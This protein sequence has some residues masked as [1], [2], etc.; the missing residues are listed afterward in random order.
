LQVDVPDLL[1]DYHFFGRLW[2]LFFGSLGR[3]AFETLSLR[4]VLLFLLTH[5]V[6][7]LL[8]LIL[9]LLLLMTALLGQLHLLLLHIDLLLAYLPF[10]RLVTVFVT[11]WMLSFVPSVTAA[12]WALHKAN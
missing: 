9:Q 1:L 2:E 12:A 8:S 7:I 3:E 4:S 10:A 5:Q 11:T 6:L